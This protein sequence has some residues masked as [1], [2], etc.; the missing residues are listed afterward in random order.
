[1]TSGAVRDNDIFD[2]DFATGE[3]SHKK[4]F[5][6]AGNIIGAYAICKR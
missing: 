4:N 5:K 3:I 2:C 6:D 1:M